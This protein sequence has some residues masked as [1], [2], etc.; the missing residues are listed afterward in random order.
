V[1]PAA[2]HGGAFGFPGNMFMGGFPP[3]GFG[4]FPPQQPPQGNDKK[5]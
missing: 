1:Q 4:G 3:A 2:A 5:E